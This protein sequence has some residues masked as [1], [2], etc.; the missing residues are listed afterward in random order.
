M[1]QIIRF[2]N[3]DQ[4]IT[5]D[6]S[7]KVSSNTGESQNGTYSLATTPTAQFFFLFRG[8]FTLNGSVPSFS[9]PWPLIRIS[10]PR[11]KHQILWP[12]R[13]RWRKLTVPTRRQEYGC[14]LERH[15]LC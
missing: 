14:V 2:N 5:Y 10:P 9:F 6:A 12:F 4:R 8:K 1:E 13:W 7:W 3:T 11:Y 15:K